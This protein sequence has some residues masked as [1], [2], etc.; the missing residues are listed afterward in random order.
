M[1]GDKQ[2][3]FFEW[4][5]G[6]EVQGESVVIGYVEINGEQLPVYAT[7]IDGNTPITAYNMNR[8]QDLATT[9]IDNK[10]INDFSLQNSKAYSANYISSCNAY[11]TGEI[12]TGKT[13]IDGKPIYRKVSE[14]GQ[15]GTS[16]KK[17][18]EGSYET[19]VSFDGYITNTTGTIK[20][21]LNSYTPSLFRYFTAEVKNNALTILINKSDSTNWA[22]WTLT[23]IIEYT[24][25]TATEE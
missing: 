23:V 10:I 6:E 12:N 2:M 25:P 7:K 18:V 5:D 14:L 8:M 4:E 19:L 16:N 1:K 24:K 9:Y 11:S 22:E 15:L 20:E 3:V 17:I 21:S 13:W